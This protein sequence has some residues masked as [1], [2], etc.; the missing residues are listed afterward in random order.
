MDPKKISTIQFK[1]ELKKRGLLTSGIKKDFI[2]R[3][4]QDDPSSEWLNNIMRT[5]VSET[6]GRQRDDQ[7]IKDL[8]RRYRDMQLEKYQCHVGIGRIFR[9]QCWFRKWEQQ[10]RQLYVTYY[11]DRAKLLVSNKLKE[12]NWFQAE[13]TIITSLEIRFQENV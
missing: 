4:D 13:N 1:A 10:V 2:A 7:S 11:L 5:E 12:K 6:N 3:L 9:W 8:E